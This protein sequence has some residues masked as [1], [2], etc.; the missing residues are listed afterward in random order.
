MTAAIASGSAAFP[1]ASGACPPSGYKP[2]RCSSFPVPSAHDSPSFSG[3]LRS[4][5]DHS[6]HRLA[7]PA[8]VHRWTLSRPAIAWGGPGLNRRCH[9]I[10]S[11]VD[12][13]KWAYAAKTGFAS[14]GYKGSPVLISPASSASRL[15]G[16]ASG[17]RLMATSS[18]GNDSIRS[19]PVRLCDQMSTLLSGGQNHCHAS[20][21]K[22]TFSWKKASG[23]TQRRI[24][25]LPETLRNSHRAIDL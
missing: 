14:S 20:K 2:A 16:M 11:D 13:C 17:S 8:A 9:T 12:V 10:A 5:H 25:I 24:T 4:D 23:P 6:P 1:S 21:G 3:S 15:H 22:I 7:R 19:A 18:A